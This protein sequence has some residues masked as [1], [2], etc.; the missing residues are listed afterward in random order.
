MPCCVYS[1]NK[2]GH[3]YGFICYCKT[4]SRERAASRLEALYLQRLVPRPA[5]PSGLH[6]VCTLDGCGHFS[7]NVEAAACGGS[8]IGAVH[9]T[10]T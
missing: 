7:W 1:T 8:H 6:R 3:I 5:A 4:M 2:H 9:T 10:N